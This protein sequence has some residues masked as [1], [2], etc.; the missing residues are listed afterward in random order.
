MNVVISTTRL[1]PA[2]HVRRPATSACDTARSA[3][4]DSA[5]LRDHAVADG[6]DPHVSCKPGPLTL[7]A[8][9]AETRPPRQRR[10]R[11]S[12]ESDGGGRMSSRDHDSLDRQRDRLD[13]NNRQLEL[14]GLVALSPD[15]DGPLLDLCDSDGMR[16]LRRGWEG[17][18]VRRR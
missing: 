12:N 16:L 14:L 2:G 4:R 10:R 9:P 11:R 17:G 18:S 13:Y 5:L 7:E 8:G 3:I 1:P 15:D 6:D